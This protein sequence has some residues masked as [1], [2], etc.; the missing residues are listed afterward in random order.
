MVPY[1][2]DG[3]IVCGGQTNREELYIAPTILRNVSPDS[4]VMQNEIFGPIL[5]VLPIKNVEEALQ[6]V[7][8]R[9][10]PLA[11]Y[12]FSEDRATVD[13]VL[14]N[15]TSGGACVNETI[16]HLVVPGLP[17][18]GVGNS[19]MGKYHGE[20][21]FRDF[22]NARAVLDRGTSFDPAVRYPPYSPEKTHLMKKL[23]TMHTPAFLEPI[24]HFILARWGDFLL[25]FIK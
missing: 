21:G 7:A 16:N 1:L 2:K 13:H 25:K 14:A 15:S 5:P 3:E 9:E 11:F 6:F 4:A 18:G 22:S 24:M 12:I 17:V 23:L 10:K 19:G 20:W 8:S